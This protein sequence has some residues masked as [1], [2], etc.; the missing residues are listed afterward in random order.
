MAK[1]ANLRRLHQAEP[2]TLEKAPPVGP[3][4]ERA[5]R[6]RFAIGRTA[7][8]EPGNRRGERTDL[9]AIA[10]TSGDEGYSLDQ[11][12][13]AQLIGQAG[14]KSATGIDGDRLIAGQRMA[15]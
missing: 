15:P 1:E 9:A 4:P 7:E 12:T 2:P 10:A 14:V 3:P 8:E 11:G 6:A 13:V 5:V